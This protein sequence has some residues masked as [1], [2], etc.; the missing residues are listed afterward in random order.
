MA[1]NL[2]LKRYIEV[3]TAFVYKGETKKPA[4][5]SSDLQP[6]TR[7]AKYKLEVI[8]NHLGRLPIRLAHRK[9]CFIKAEE[10]I[11][12][13]PGI[14]LVIVRPAVVYGPADF[15]GLMPRIVC[16]AS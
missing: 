16:A 8:K 13:L 15:A 5:E 6:W 4:T 9:I 2:G 7:Q 11:R 1:Q 14:N 3:S 12:K 10:E